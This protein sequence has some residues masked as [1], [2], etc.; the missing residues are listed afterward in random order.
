VSQ[1]QSA[2]VSN[3][4]EQKA[5][6]IAPAL[7]VAPALN[8]SVLSFGGQSIHQANSAKAGARNVN[9]TDQEVSQSQLAD[10]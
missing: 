6:A 10:A 3:S 8:L 5:V 7:Q 2:D 9:A 1:R 4:T